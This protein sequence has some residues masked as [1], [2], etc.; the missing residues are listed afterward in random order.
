[1]TS[2]KRIAA[3]AFAITAL[4]FTTAAAEKNVCTDCTGYCECT[5]KCWDVYPDDASARAAC[6]D[7][8]ERLY[9]PDTACLCKAGPIAN[10]RKRHHD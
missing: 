9:N 8:C 7:R 3:A 2:L 1:M 5:Q 4:A 10:D 6:L